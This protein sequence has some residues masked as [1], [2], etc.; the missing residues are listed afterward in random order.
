MDTA[1]QLPTAQNQ[2]SQISL[3]SLATERAGKMIGCYRK[4][5]AADPHTYAAAVVAV[6]VRWPPEVIM[7]VTEPATGIPSK[8]NWL[9]SIAEITQACEDAYEPIRARLEIERT[10]RGLPAPHIERPTQ[11]ELDEQF[12]RLGLQHLRVK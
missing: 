11:S 9:P 4:S 8:I 10:K 5:D 6:L 2:A 1:K 12:R 3:R 7:K